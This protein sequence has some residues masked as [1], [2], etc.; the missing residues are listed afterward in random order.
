MHIKYLA[1]PDD[2]KLKSSMTFFAE[3]KNS[4]PVFQSVLDH[5]FNGEKDNRTLQIINEVN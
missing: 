1:A 4:N 3:V 5:F 2:L